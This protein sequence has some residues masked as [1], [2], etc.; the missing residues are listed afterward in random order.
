LSKTTYSAALAQP[1]QEYAFGKLKQV[2]AWNGATGTDQAGTLKSVA[3]GAGNVIQLSNW[4]RGVPRLIRH[5]ATPEAPAGATQSAV[6]DDAGW[7]TSVT[8]E[9][10][11]TTGYQHDLMGRL[12]RVTYPVED[13]IHGVVWNPTTHD[14]AQQAAAY[15]LPQHWRWQTGTGNARTV[16]HLDAMWRPVVEERYDSANPAATRS[17]V[18]KRYDD[19]GRLAFQSHPMRTLADYRTVTAGTYSEYDALGRVTKTWVPSVDAP[20]GKF[21]TTTEYLAGFL[22]KV[23][24][25]NLRV[26]TT[27]FLAWDEPTTDYPVQV[28]HPEGAFTHITRDAF[29]KPIVLRR[30]DSSSPVGGT[31]A[32]D[33]TYAYNKHQELCRSVEPETGATLM[34]YDPAG[35]LAW[36]A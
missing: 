23:T 36:S 28:T 13:P 27:R 4:K 6:V 24:S 33:R 19:A 1:E 2:T 34:G 31:L 11:A 29:G 35:N 32:V 3:D 5:P 20:G 26:T 17:I 25:P 22:Q 14:F 7:I 12:T 16:I 15:G 8:D 18:V 10:G 30:S 9:V 21:T